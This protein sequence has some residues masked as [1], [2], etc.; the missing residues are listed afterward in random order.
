[1]NHHKLAFTIVDSHCPRQRKIRPQV[2]FQCKRQA[3]SAWANFLRRTSLNFLWQMLIDATITQI[4]EVAHINY[5]DILISWYLESLKFV[6]CVHV[7]SL[8]SRQFLLRKI[9]EQQF[10]TM[11]CPTP[12]V[13]KCPFCT[14]QLKHVQHYMVVAHQ[15]ECLIHNG[16]LKADQNSKPVSKKIIHQWWLSLLEDFGKEKHLPL[17]FGQINWCQLKPR[18]KYAVSISLLRM[19]NHCQQIT[20]HVQQ[21]MNYSS[22]GLPLLIAPIP[23]PRTA[24]DSPEYLELTAS[25]SS[26][27]TNSRWCNMG[28]RENPVTPV[29]H[30]VPTIVVGYPE[31]SPIF[32]TNH[33]EG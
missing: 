15:Q 4:L 24:K 8:C 14:Q 2:G 10:L 33:Y 22:T 16:N 17:T 11:R 13:N 3:A 27:P 6:A 28:V 9:K 26:L 32:I 21:S 19:I 7:F 23:A 29:Y 25:R 30:C 12:I 20:D 18:R 31:L 1:M 5:P